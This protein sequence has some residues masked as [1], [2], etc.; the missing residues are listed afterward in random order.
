VVVILVVL[1]SFLYIYILLCWFEREVARGSV[2]CIDI[3]WT[4]KGCFLN[5]V[6]LTLSPLSLSLCEG[7]RECGTARKNCLK[8]DL[9][10]S[11]GYLNGIGF[12]TVFLSLC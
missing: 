9:Y 4:K 6:L 11:F 7:R 10:I 8:G 1:Y 2:F 5:S 12:S 3:V